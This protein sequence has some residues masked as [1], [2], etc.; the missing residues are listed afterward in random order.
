[1]ATPPAPADPSVQEAGQSN[2]SDQSATSNATSTQS[3]ATNTNIPVR[4]LSPGN[5]GSVSQSNSSTA[6]SVAANLNATSQSTGQQQ[7]GAGGA[8]VQAAGQDNAS[9]QSAESTASSTQDHPANYNIPVRV[10]SPG[11]DGDVEQSNSST[12]VSIGANAEPDRAGHPP[13]AGRW[14]R[15]T[16]RAGRRAAERERAARE[17]GCHVDPD[18]C[19]ELQHPGSRAEPGQ[20]RVGRA[21]ERLDGPLGGGEPEQDRSGDRAAPGWAWG[22]RTPRWSRRPGR[23]RATVSPPARRRRPRSRTRPTPT[24]RCGCSAPG[25]T[26]R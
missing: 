18:G 25:T 9:S 26:A 24:S 6:G 12:A 23:R 22:T 3:G 4:V 5:D 13:E 10:L 20:R 7:A 16:V 14:R 19:G 8:G 1:M 17:L 15:R 2:S 21:V 11:H